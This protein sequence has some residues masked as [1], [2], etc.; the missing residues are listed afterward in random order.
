MQ[1]N[2]AQ[3]AHAIIQ[4]VPLYKVFLIEKCPLPYVTVYVG[5]IICILP[6]TLK[7][8]TNTEWTYSGNFTYWIWKNEEKMLSKK[9]TKLLQLC[10]YNVH[11][12]Y[13]KYYF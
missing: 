8:C 11:R 2:I 4:I 5:L 12:T 13:C 7:I 6:F 3:Y 9:F 10:T 1:G